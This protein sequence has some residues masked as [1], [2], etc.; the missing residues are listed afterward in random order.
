M[1][2]LTPILVTGKIIEGL[3]G[4]SGLRKNPLS[5]EH[6][7]IVKQKPYFKSAGIKRVESWYNGTINI[8]IAPKKFKIIEPDYAVTAE[9][10]PRTTETFWL[11]DVLLKY[12]GKSYPAYIYYPCPSPVKAHPDT[13]IEILAEHINSVN[14]GDDADIELLSNNVEIID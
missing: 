9:W 12:E 5:N 13:L 11:V 8:T 3:R 10:K 7:S 4:A 6:G 14:Y 2:N 1:S